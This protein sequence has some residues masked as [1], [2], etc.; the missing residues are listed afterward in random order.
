MVI[1]VVLSVVLVTAAAPLHALPAFPGAEGFGAQTPGGRA[2]QVLKVTTLEDGDEPGTFRWAVTREYPRIVV[3]E[4]SGTVVLKEP[5]FV[6]SAERG[7]LTVAGQ[8][9][10]GGGICISNAGFVLRNTHDVVLRHLRIRTGDSGPQAQPDALA[11]I[12]CQRVV[13]DHCSISWGVDECFSITSHPEEAHGRCRDITAQWCMVHEGLQESTHPKGPHSKGLMVAY[14]PASVSLHHNLIAHCWDRNPYLPTEGHVPYIIDVVN[15]VVYN[16]GCAAGIGYPK[17][18]HNGRIN[19]VGN[20]YIPGP[21]SVMQPSLSMGVRAR[22][23]ASGNIDCVRTGDDQDQFRSV[24]WI[25]GIE[26]TE[27]LK[28]GARF[29]APPV[30]TWDYATAT[31]MV[32][33]H[34]GATL[35]ERDTADA[36]VVADVRNGSGRIIDH[37][38]DVGGWPELAAGEVPADADDDG[39]PDAWERER[40]LDPGDSADATQDRDG[41]GYTN[42]E[43]YINGLCPVPGQ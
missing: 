14:G 24:R 6:E 17:E 33:E 5:L 13:V 43:E 41:D 2:G 28:A 12:T 21:D 38:S 7:F 29:D 34:A 27:E 40:G 39:M 10:P 1:R 37:P 22:I 32:L 19:L 18:N 35:P 8:T 20:H 42:V 16:W 26:D 25:G 23:H 31:E 11:I 15:N 9:A 4:V 3:F 36:R 30:T